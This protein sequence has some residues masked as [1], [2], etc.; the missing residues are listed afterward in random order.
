MED[1]LEDKTNVGK[2]DDLSRTETEFL[3]IVQYCVHVLNPNCIYW[4]VEHVPTSCS[5]SA[6]GT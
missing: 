5:I 3:V 1:E 6:G 2:F 4:T